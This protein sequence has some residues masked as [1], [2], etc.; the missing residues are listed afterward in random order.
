MKWASIA[1]GLLAVVMVVHL[2]WH[3]HRH[4]RTAP[5]E[6]LWTKEDRAHAAR[7]VR[8]KKIRGKGWGVVARRDIPKWTLIGPYP[9]IVSTEEHHESLKKKG[10]VDDEYAVEF[11][12]SSPGGPISE[13]M[14]LN[15]RF[16]GRMLP[17]FRGCIT[18]FVN[19][20]DTRKRPN[21]AWV[22]NFPKHR[23]EMWTAKPVKRGE[24]L[25]ICYGQYYGRKYNTKCQ[26][27]G[28]ELPRRVIGSPD[29]RKPLNWYDVIRHNRD[30]RVA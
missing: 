15:P 17:V 1:V 23:I 14:I 3:S 24:E 29:Q 27:K 16:K 7:Y 19:E 9:G 21:V 11:W 12:S 6:V 2:A 8:R 13:H 20:P 22:W 28:V 4:Q 30:P 18:P 25:T 26:R 10:V 5:S